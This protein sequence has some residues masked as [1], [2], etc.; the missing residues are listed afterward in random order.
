MAPRCVLLLLLAISVQ[1]ARRAVAVRVVETGEVRLADS[2]SRA[3]AAPVHEAVILQLLGDV[4]KH[5]ETVQ[6]Q[7]Y[8]D[9]Q[10]LRDAGSPEDV[11]LGYALS[12]DKMLDAAENL[13][14]ATLLAVSAQ[15][16]ADAKAEAEAAFAHA[17]SVTEAVE[18]QTATHR[19]ARAAA[20]ANSKAAAEAQAAAEASKVAEETKVAVALTAAQEKAAKEK[21]AQEKAAQEKAAQEK[22]AQEKAAAEAQKAAAEA[23]EQA[24]AA[25]QAEADR[26]EKQRLAAERL[27]VER[28]EAE[29]RR[30]Q[31][32]LAAQLAVAAGGAAA[33]TTVVS[34]APAREDFSGQAAGE[35]MMGVAIAMAMMAMAMAIAARRQRGGNAASAALTNAASAALT[36]PSEAA[37]GESAS[38]AAATVEA[39]TALNTALKKTKR[40]KKKATGGATQTLWA[41]P[42]YPLDWA[43]A[44][45][46]SVP[47][48]STSSALP[49]PVAC[50]VMP[51]LSPGWVMAAKPKGRRSIKSRGEA[52][53]GSPPTAS[54]RTLHAPPSLEALL[55]CAASGEHDGPVQGRE[56]SIRSAEEEEGDAAARARERRTADAALQRAIAVGML[57]GVRFALSRATATGVDDARLEAARTFLATAA[58]AAVKVAAAQPDAPDATTGAEPGS[59]IVEAT[60]A[61]E[62]PPI[63]NWLRHLDALGAAE[64]DE[65]DSD[66]GDEKANQEQELHEKE[67][68]PLV[69][70]GADDEEEMEEMEEKEP[71]AIE[72]DVSFDVREAPTPEATPVGSVTPLRLARTPLEEQRSDQRVLSVRSE[73]GA[74]IEPG[75][76]GGVPAL[77]SLFETG[78]GVGLANPLETVAS[79]AARPPAKLGMSHAASLRS[80]RAAL[81]KEAADKAAEEEAMHARAEAEKPTEDSPPAELDEEDEDEEDEGEEDEG[82]EHGVELELEPVVIADDDDDDDDDEE[83]EDDDDDDVDEEDDARVSPHSAAP[84]AVAM[85]HAR[86]P[87]WGIARMSSFGGSLSSHSVLSPMSLVAQAR[88]RV[89]RARQAKGSSPFSP[90]SADM[91]SPDMLENKPPLDSPRAPELSI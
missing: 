45:P 75:A 62:P 54:S 4:V 7:V 52:E 27:K 37:A 57:A 38:M 60:A 88:A 15:Q 44:T 80:K 83:E 84:R 55:Q 2:I 43:P 13:D 14:R 64:D 23:A 39:E 77:V 24:A 69:H 32:Q 3:R 53:G 34:A 48:E 40:K 91:L 42:A 46:S 22:A 59:E 9:T 65:A 61:P 18:A 36:E 81:Q 68:E 70:D 86:L 89:A 71:E 49:L 90:Q 21:A 73:V 82:E 19:E 29:Q 66:Y 50:Q 31:Q 41:P 74:M 63:E 67:G 56:Q 12:M 11:S 16:A 87:K 33:T 5:A 28:I 26:L 17:S 76:A 10:W 25:R 47:A 8:A 72:K 6:S 30:Q 85:Q 78:T 20:G 58:A 51:P 35:A 1:S 79:V